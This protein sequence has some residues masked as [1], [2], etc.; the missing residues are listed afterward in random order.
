M[1]GVAC[2]FINNPAQQAAGQ[3]L[4]LTPDYNI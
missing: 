1:L 4:V 3:L 2:D